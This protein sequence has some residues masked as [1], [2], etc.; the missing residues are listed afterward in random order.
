MTRNFRLHYKRFSFFLFCVGGAMQLWDWKR[1]LSIYHIYRIELTAYDRMR[2]QECSHTHTIYTH[3]NETTHLIH[4]KIFTH[5][6]LTLFTY[7]HT[8]KHTHWEGET[9]TGTGWN[10]ACLRTVWMYRT[11][12]QVPRCLVLSSAPK[13]TGFTGKLYGNVVS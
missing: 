3:R 1:G 7:S 9:R 6:C 13:G 2:Q 4:W 5:T 10:V 11:F 8:H 12:V